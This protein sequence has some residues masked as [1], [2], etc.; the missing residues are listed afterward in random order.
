M[1]DY[2]QTFAHLLPEA[3]YGKSKRET[4]FFSHSLAKQHSEHLM[5]KLNI[6]DT[7]D[8][9]TGVNRFQA[10]AG[11]NRSSALRWPC[12]VALP[13]HKRATSD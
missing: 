11:P 4:P 13:L 9:R 10:R 5:E 7:A 12:A 3:R 8:L 1:S 6:H 2:N